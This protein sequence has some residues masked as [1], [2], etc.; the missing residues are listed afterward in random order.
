MMKNKPIIGIIQSMDIDNPIQSY[1]SGLGY[2]A[3]RR[4]PGMGSIT[5]EVRFDLTRNTVKKVHKYFSD[6]EGVEIFFRKKRK[7]ATI[8]HDK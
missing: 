5:I 4:L 1:D 7:K 6:K 8:C 2:I 3:H